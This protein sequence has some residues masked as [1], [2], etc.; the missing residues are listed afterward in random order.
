MANYQNH[1]IDPT[2]FWDAIEEFS[3]DFDWFIVSSVTSDEL[4]RDKYS[5]T[6]DTIRGSLQS[7]GTSLSL[8][9]TG[10]TENMEYEFY[11][12]SIFRIKVGDFI[13][14]KNRWL[15]VESVRD[16]DEFGC[17]SARL[18]MVNLNNYNDLLEYI[19]YLDGEILV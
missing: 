15:H 5:Y 19:K 1:V 10:N 4:F 14:Y 13:L 6:K 9:K 12:K 3:F 18:R 7:Q 17:R 8:S 11:C 16:I 2:W